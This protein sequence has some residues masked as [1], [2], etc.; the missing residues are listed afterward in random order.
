MPEQEDTPVNKSEKALNALGGAA[1]GSLIAMILALSHT[2]VAS[3]TLS[4][5]IGGAIVFLALQDNIL[6]SR[7]G[8]MTEV[9]IYRIIGFSMAAVLAL[10][11]GIHLRATNALG[12][13]EAKRLY[14][15]LVEIGIPHK[16][17]RATV[18]DHV[19]STKNSEDSDI[20]RLIGTSTLFTGGASEL[21]CADLAPV[22]FN[23]AE[24][25]IA[26]YTTE[27]GVWAEIAKRVSAERTVDP[28]IHAMSFVKGLY[29]VNC[30]RAA[31]QL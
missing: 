1:L 25:I 21:T 17:A 14:D 26:R 30:D 28:S 13:S 7:A 27:G 24:S 16:E 11:I 29:A 31:W 4:V 22:K 15:D 9:L 20:E 10:L 18:L 8:T 6:P 23:N 19:K 2:A 3:A 12:E 5:L